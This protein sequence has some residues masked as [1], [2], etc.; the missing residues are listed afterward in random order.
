M[1][2]ERPS[3][4]STGRVIDLEEGPRLVLTRLRNPIGNKTMCLE[5]HDLQPLPEDQGGAHFHARVHFWLLTDPL[6]RE[7]RDALGDLLPG[8]A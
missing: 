4:A 3:G 8:G 1:G 5:V 2:H 6:A 7:L